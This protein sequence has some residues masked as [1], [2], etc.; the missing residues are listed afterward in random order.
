[1]LYNFAVHQFVRPQL[2]EFNHSSAIWLHSILFFL[3]FFG[4]QARISLLGEV[5]R[6]CM[7]DNN[8]RRGAAI[9]GFQ[10][11]LF[12]SRIELCRAST[13]SLLI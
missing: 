5:D 11:V 1:M 4:S 10:I 6:A 3:V 13:K 8:R 12:R 2:R 9:A 7:D